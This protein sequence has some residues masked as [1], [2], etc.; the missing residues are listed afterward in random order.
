MDLQSLDDTQLASLA[1]QGYLTPQTVQQIQAQRLG[2][3]GSAGDG[4][5]GG[6]AVSPADPL[7]PGFSAAPPAAP[8]ASTSDASPFAGVS[9]SAQGTTAV[10]RPT[11][12][13]SIL[14]GP[15]GDIAESIAPAPTPARM[16]AEEDVKRAA[17]GKPPGD[18]FVPRA[19]A[20][21]EP[22]A[23]LGP[24]AA[25]AGSP[26]GPPLAFA[27]PTGGVGSAAQKAYLA[28]LGQTEAQKAAAN[29]A[30]AGAAANT[31]AVAKQQGTSDASALQN[32][33]DASD[34]VSGQESQHDALVA[35]GMA[36]AD[37]DIERQR[38]AIKD[39]DPER[40]WNSKT[41]GEN[42]LAGIAVALGAFGA[43]MPH[44][45][46]GG[47]NYALE[48]INNATAADIA[49]QESNR[50]AAFDKLDISKGAQKD[51]FLRSQWETNQLGKERIVAND[52][53]ALQIRQQAALTGSADKQQAAQGL[54]SDLEKQSADERAKMAAAQYQASLK[55]AGAGAGTTLADYHAYVKGALAKDPNAPTLSAGEWLARMGGQSGG[56]GSGGSD[57]D[58]AR[59][60][61]EHL[62]AGALEETKGKAEH[63]ATLQQIDAAA[64]AALDPKASPL[65]AMRARALHRS[66]VEEE[67]HKRFPGKSQE[68]IDSFVKPALLSTGLNPLADNETARAAARKL[69]PAPATPIIDNLRGGPA[70]GAPLVLQP[71][72]RKATP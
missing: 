33:A 49:S 27:R 42:V 29:Q 32:A 66:L 61:P 52:K 6:D 24:S 23:P 56:V 11:G 71:G 45:G 4:T 46:L 19:P 16:Q 43:G 14:P 54:I 63:A 20:P 44:S 37:R 10:P 53:A 28:T 38:A 31:S 1:Q 69:F 26:A 7:P 8:S 47:R 2:G 9:A 67:G 34:Y 59:R 41:T 13:A 55:L 70:P 50:K 57:M 25:A 15:L 39:V 72:M 5:G 48:I 51:Q 12:P 35:Q 40:L 68:V 21:G 22:L 64:A 58:I 18:T 36:A 60:A 62:R 3:G 30:L 17:E 65:E